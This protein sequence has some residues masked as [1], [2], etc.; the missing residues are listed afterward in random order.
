M[1]GE[2]EWCDSKTLRDITVGCNNGAECNQK[3]MRWWDDRKTRNSRVLHKGLWGN[4]LTD[5]C[6]QKLAAFK[7]ELGHA[8]GCLLAIGTTNSDKL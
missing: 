5:P 4:A 2:H 7:G 1:G 6:H 3:Q 8:I